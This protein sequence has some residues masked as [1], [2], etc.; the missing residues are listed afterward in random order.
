MPMLVE[1]SLGLSSGKITDQQRARSAIVYVRQSTYKQV[2]HNRE[3]QHNQYGLVQ[4][5]LELGWIPERV[6]VFDA[7]Q[8]HSGQDGCER[9]SATLWQ[10]FRWAGSAWC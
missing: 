9:I 10:R 4:R 8:G 6:R 2:Q 1:G 3:S 7:D 5:A